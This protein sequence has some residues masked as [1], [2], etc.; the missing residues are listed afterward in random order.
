MTDEEKKALRKQRHEWEC[1]EV[2]AEVPTLRR[3]GGRWQKLHQSGW[4]N[5][6]PIVELAEPVR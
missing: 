4:R 2:L 3:V 5:L 1:K 6:D